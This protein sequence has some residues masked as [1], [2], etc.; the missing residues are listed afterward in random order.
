MA[1]LLVFSDGAVHWNISFSRAAQDWELDMFVV[2]FD[3][4][5]AMSIDIEGED[6]M[7]WNLGGNKKVLGTLLLE[8]SFEIV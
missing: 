3:S 2:F 5:Y 8:G 7:I 1:S 4:L 6:K